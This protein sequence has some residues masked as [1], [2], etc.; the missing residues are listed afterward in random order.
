MGNALVHPGQVRRFDNLAGRSFVIGVGAQKAG[1]TWLFEY[2]GQ[3]PDVAM[4]PIKE[5][6]FFDVI[7][8]PDLCAFFSENFRRDAMDC[9]RQLAGGQTVPITK[10]RYL[11][12]R[13]RMDTE[14]AAY[15]NILTVWPHMGGASSAR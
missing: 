7:H 12:D 4:S 15:S 13:V 11:L 9:I 3:H 10:L 5:L 14:P 2:L 1:T 8:R 6:H